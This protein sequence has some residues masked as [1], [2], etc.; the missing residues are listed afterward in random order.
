MRH[1]IN[2][3][4]QFKFKHLVIYFK[5]LICNFLLA[6]TGEGIE[7]N[8]SVVLFVVILVRPYTYL[9]SL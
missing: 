4:T 2:F 6:I 9:V 1:I 3:I 8:L 7:P 5:L